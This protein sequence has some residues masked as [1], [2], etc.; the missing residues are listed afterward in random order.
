MRLAHSV[1][2]ESINDK[3]IFKALFIAGYPGSGKTTLI[4][5]IHDGSLPVM[6]VNSDIWTEYY[7]KFDRTAWSDIG[8]LVKRHSLNNVYYHL[9]GL[10]PLYIDSTSTNSNMF[11]QRVEILKQMGYDLK[12]FLLDIDVGISKARALSREKAGGRHVDME[13]IDKAY[14]IINRDKSMYKSMVPNFK[15]LKGD[16]M[17]PQFINKVS[18]EVFSFYSSPVKSDRGKEILDFMK[19][20][21]YKYYN[22]IPKEIINEKGWYSLD[23]STLNWY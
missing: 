8:K 19:Q 1:L 3:G 17:T 7:L 5:K 9:N 12:M 21:R 13:Y 11:K 10:L 6:Q 18:N 4:K 20:Q 22:D 23:K 16:E 2:T 15:V 14:E